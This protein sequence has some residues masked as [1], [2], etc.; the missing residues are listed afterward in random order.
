MPYADARATP[1][2]DEQTRSGRRAVAGVSSQAHRRRQ[3]ACRGASSASDAYGYT[4]NCE[5]L[6][7]VWAATS[8]V[9]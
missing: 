2:A 7:S 9:K 8:A 4:P 6:R 3:R 5:A 1:N